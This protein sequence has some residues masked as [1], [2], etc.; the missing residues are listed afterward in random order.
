MCQP[1]IESATAL[2][3]NRNYI[4]CCFA[5][6]RFKY[7][8]CNLL[9]LALWGELIKDL[10]NFNTRLQQNSAS[11]VVSILTVFP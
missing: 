11:S 9:Y 7:R 2:S 1:Y 6:H 4:H 5:H 10:H 8:T 3:D